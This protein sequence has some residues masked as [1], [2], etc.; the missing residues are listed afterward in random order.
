MRNPRHQLATGGLNGGFALPGLGQAPA[1]GLK[2]LGQFGEFGRHGGSAPPT[3]RHGMFQCFATPQ[4]PGSVHQ[5]GSVPGDAGTKH[6]G[7]CNSNRR[8]SGQ[9]VPHDFEVPRGDEHGG[10]G[11][12]HARH[13]NG[14]GGHHHQADLG[15]Y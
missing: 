9:D 6:E 2:F 14:N 4:A 10:E 1:A 13:Q 3:L 8:G 15:E 12:D 5:V 11:T 7:Q